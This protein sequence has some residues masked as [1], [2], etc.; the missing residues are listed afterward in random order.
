M[1]HDYYRN[2]MRKNSPWHQINLSGV[3]N[4][5]FSKHVDIIDY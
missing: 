2:P 5:N 4:D 3:N 1:N